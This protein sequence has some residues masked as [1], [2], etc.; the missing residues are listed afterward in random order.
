MTMG[1]NSFFRGGALFDVGCA[2][3]VQDRARYRAAPPAAPASACGQKKDKGNAP[4][5]N[6]YAQFV[7]TEYSS[8]ES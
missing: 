1:V 5:G 6:G 8:G 2:R 4:M 7:E 3:G